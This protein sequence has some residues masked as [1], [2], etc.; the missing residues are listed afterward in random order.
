MSASACPEPLELSVL[1]DYWLGDLAPA[2][3]ER[4][5]EHFLSCA[6]CS[7]RMGDFVALTD[8]VRGLANLGVVRAVVTSAFLE[9]LVDEGLRVR[10]YRLVPGGSVECTVTPSDDLVAA[11][12]AA[13]LRGVQHIDLVKCD[14]EG[15][16]ENRLKDIPVSASA[17]E[18]VL[19]E[20]ID[21][22]RALPAGVHLVRLVAPDADGERLL[23]EYTFIHTSSTHE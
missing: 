6:A 10:E 7:E 3:E 22:L 11:R 23:A 18:V 13:D 15:R 17:R 8:G 14:A 2:E 21:R 12:L 4:V 16:E 5:E 1:V 20:R 19:L 9:R